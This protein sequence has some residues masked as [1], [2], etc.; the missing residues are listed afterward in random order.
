M[1]FRIVMSTGL[2][3]LA[4]GLAQA[5]SAAPASDAWSRPAPAASAA[6]PAHPGYGQPPGSG[7]SQ[8]QV[9]FKFKERSS[10]PPRPNAALEA[11][12]K[13]GVGG[14]STLDRNGR[15]TVNCMQTP[16]DPACR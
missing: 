10:T 6:S 15:P 9:H 7:E 13:A 4:G 2:L 5:Q 14:G 16:M 8:R 1:S 12:G 3:L 11:S